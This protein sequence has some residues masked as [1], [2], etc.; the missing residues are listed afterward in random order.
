MI[1]ILRQAKQIKEYAEKLDEKD[2]R[3]MELQREYTQFIHTVTREQEIAKRQLAEVQEK[4][5]TKTRQ[6][7]EFGSLIGG[8]R[9]MMQNMNIPV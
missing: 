4:L 2:V 5:D 9:R 8:F 3:Y 6:M 7:Y 1:S